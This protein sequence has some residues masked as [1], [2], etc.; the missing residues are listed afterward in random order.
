[1]DCYVI[2]VMASFLLF[3]LN[4]RAV[5]SVLQYTINKAMCSCPSTHQCTM[6]YSNHR[7]VVVNVISVFLRLK[8]HRPL[9]FSLSTV[10]VC[11]SMR[12][13]R[14][15]TF[16][17][18]SPQSHGQVGGHPDA[19][20]CRAINDSTTFRRRMNKVVIMT[21]N[22]SIHLCLAVKLLHMVKHEHYMPDLPAPLS[23]KYDSSPSWSISEICASW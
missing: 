3:L 18:T 6:I 23:V 12:V 19:S 13:W 16:G 9:L 8:H 4:S 7:G 21:Y 1:M 2:I 15:S 22:C 20:H 17:Q 5:C 10:S 14:T 11:L